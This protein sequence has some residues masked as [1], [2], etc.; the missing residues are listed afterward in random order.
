[1]SLFLIVK[2]ARYAKSAILKNQSL[3]VIL[4][5]LYFNFAY[6]YQILLEANIV[7]QTLDAI[8][9]NKTKFR[10]QYEL[11]RL[12]LGLTNVVKFQTENNA[13]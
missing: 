11:N 1:M 2:I 7:D 12:I 8:T 10:K 13:F 6:T 5:C 3:N 9:Q 4:L